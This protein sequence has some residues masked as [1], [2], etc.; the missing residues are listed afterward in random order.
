[1][2][3]KLTVQ[4]NVRSIKMFSESSSCGAAFPVLIKACGG[5]GG[6]LKAK[7]NI[8]LQLEKILLIANKLCNGGV[9]KPANRPS[10]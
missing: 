7:E 1:M 4:D 2:V 10:T 9:M 8:Q 6:G 5:G 3:V